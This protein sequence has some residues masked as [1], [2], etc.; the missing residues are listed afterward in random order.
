MSPPS[1]GSFGHWLPIETA[2]RD[3][4]PVLIFSVWSDRTVGCWSAH[5]GIWVDQSHGVVVATH[6][7]PLPDPPED[8]TDH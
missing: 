7:M 4:S 2:P 6:W 8:T 5:R 1:P 3:G